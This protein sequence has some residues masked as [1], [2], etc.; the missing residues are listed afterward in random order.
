M[1]IE[2]ALKVGLTR[3]AQLIHAVQRVFRDI[4]QARFPNLTVDCAC[5]L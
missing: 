1:V 3:N 4:L 2:D 5:D